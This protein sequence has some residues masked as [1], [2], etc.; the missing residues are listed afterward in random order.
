MK[1]NHITAVFKKTLKDMLRNRRQ[2]LLFLI[3]PLMAYLFNATVEEGREIFPLTFLPMNVMFCSINIMAAVISE[4]KE[5]GTLRCLMF[6][7]VK[8]IEYFLGNGIFVL[9]VTAISSSLFIPL[10]DISGINYLYFY[11]FLILS[12]IC[13]M[14]LGAT[15]GISVKNQMAANGLCAPVTILVGM[16]PTFG[17]MNESLKG[18]SKLFYSTRFADTIGEIISK[19]AVTIDYKIIL[20][21][22]VNFIICITIFSIVYK[23][24]KLDD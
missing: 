13:S 7:N 5:K 14:V 2:L 20:T 9:L 6:A 17:A 18:I 12:S 3:F 11:G 4:E 22:V 10:I 1:L 16:L 24:K 23:K 8:P 19:T 15:I 21:Y